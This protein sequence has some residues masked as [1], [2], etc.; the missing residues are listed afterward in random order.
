MK[1]RIAAISAVAVIVILLSWGFYFY[2]ISTRNAVEKFIA[3]DIM[4]NVLI[5]GS[6]SY[7]DN[8]HKLYAV[9]SIQPGTRK[10][11]LMFLPP[12]LRV[13]TD[14]R[15][16]EYRRIDEM[17][18][19]DFDTLSQSLFNE[20][21]LK[22]PFY[23][24]LYAPDVERL[25]DLIGGLELYY[26]DQVKNIHGIKA[27]INYFDGAKIMQYINSA[28]ENSIFIKYDRI[29]DILLA[30]FTDKTKYKKLFTMEFVSET[31]KSIKTNLL[32]Q[33]ILSLGG[34]IYDKKADILCT[35]LP[36]SFT[37]NGFYHVDNI[38]YK[39]YEKEIYSL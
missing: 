35:I 1:K 31:I 6:N 25:I 11:G 39:L 8:R 7:N 29:E 20:T 33:E 21:K 16:R 17:D 5:A 34:L 2:R 10:I 32:P 13:S 3:G 36:G 12:N 15:N 27:G 9:M 30:L 14:R 26:L 28:E 37:E 18:V 24:V 4:I 22:I 19:T 23:I 38:S